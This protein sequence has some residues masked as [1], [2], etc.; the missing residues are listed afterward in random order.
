VKSISPSA[1]EASRHKNT[2][3]SNNISRRTKTSNFILRRNFHGARNVTNRDL[4]T[5]F[6][7]LN[8]LV[9][10]ELTGFNLQN[11]LTFHIVFG[12]LD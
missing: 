1:I 9:R 10:D 8:F 4:V 7:D 11:E 6:L 12:T 5:L 3:N 2:S